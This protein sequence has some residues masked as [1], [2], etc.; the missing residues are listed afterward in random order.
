MACYKYTKARMALS[1]MAD[2]VLYDIKKGKE[3]CLFT[4]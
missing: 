2:P 1:N 4:L 3:L